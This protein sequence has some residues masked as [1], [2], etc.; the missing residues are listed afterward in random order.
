ME[1]D[2]ELAEFAHGQVAVEDQLQRRV[3]EQMRAL[4]G[5][6]RRLTHRMAQEDALAGDLAP[7]VGQPLSPGEGWVGGDEC[8]VEGANA[9]PQNE[10]RADLSFEEGPHHAHLGGAK[11]TPAA[12]DKRCGHG[13]SVCRARRPVRGRSSGVPRVTPPLVT[14][15][16]E[17]VYDPLA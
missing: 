16:R 7:Q 11:N 6:P 4:P 2:F 1:G 10:I 8:A 12:K 3:R 5:D 13:G 9:R 17:V 14:R 15:A